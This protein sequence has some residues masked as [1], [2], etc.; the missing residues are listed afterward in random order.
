MFSLKSRQDNFRLLLPKEFIC[1]EIVE[2]YTKV[3]QDAHSFYTT[4]IDFLNETIQGVQ[5]LG[6]TGGTVQQQ[7]P[8]RGAWSKTQERKPLSDDVLSIFLVHSST[9]PSFASTTILLYGK[10][11]YN[12]ILIYCIS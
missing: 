5:V 11:R 6:F 9:Y 10:H 12:V 1:D 7:Q 4:P 3:L 8:G 2:K